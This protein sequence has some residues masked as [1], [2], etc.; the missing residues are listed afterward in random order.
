MKALTKKVTADYDQTKF[1]N[2]WDWQSDEYK[3]YVAQSRGLAVVFFNPIPL[4]KY[5]YD[6]KGEKVLHRGKE[7]LLGAYYGLIHRRNN[8]YNEVILA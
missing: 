2:F 6:L 5:N 1:Q 4:R 7:A 3:H 8:I